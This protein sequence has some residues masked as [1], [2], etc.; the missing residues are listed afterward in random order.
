MRYF[1]EINLLRAFAI[2][3]VISI[4]VSGAFT[5]MNP[6]SFL[7][8]LYMAI[9]TASGFAVPLFVAVSGFVLYNKYP[10]G[11]DPAAFYRKRLVSVL[12]PYL[13]FSTVYLVLDHLR[14][15]D[16]DIP[17]IAYRYLTGGWNYSYWFVVVI[18]EFYLLYPVL[19]NIFRSCD[20]RNR[21][22]ELLLAAFVLGVAYNTCLEPAVI[23]IAGTAGPA[24]GVASKFIGFLFY[25]FLGIA[26]RSRYD[27]VVTAIGSGSR[28]CLLAVPLMI[29][30]L[31]GIVS[32]AYTNF[33][34]ATVPVLKIPASSWNWLINLVSPVNYLILFSLCLVVSLHLVRSSGLLSGLLGT[35]GHYSYGIYLIHL[36]FL[37]EIVKDLNRA[38]LGWNSWLFYPAVFCL[39]VLLS[40]LAAVLIHRLPG[41]SWIIGTTR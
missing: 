5:F 8:I 4:H 1:D 19:L 24:L 15:V 7:T 33:G 41:G 14:F 2:L 37:M 30:I 10:D 9:D 6:A 34:F 36:L 27:A 11:V 40:T 25:F 31:A 3:A 21:I 13:V 20:T 12:P 17:A 38:G 29:G 32:A 22:R 16:H 23:P 35:I 39:T 18:V 28:L 26:A